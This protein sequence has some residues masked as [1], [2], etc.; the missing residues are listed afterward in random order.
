TPPVRRR[1]TPSSKAQTQ[2][3][4]PLIQ[5]VDL[6]KTPPEL[7]EVIHSEPG[8]AGER[9]SRRRR[10]TEPAAALAE[11]ET[12]ATPE[13]AGGAT[14]PAA[15]PA[16]ARRRTEVRAPP[17]SVSWGFSSRSFSASGSGFA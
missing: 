12:P 15:G 8:Q 13:G 17:S 4:Q 5:V 3:L 14:A 6:H 7:P 1:R 2:S 10:R 16:E 9:R 11:V